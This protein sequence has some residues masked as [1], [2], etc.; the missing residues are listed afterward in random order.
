MED[1][2]QI[3]KTDMTDVVDADVEVTVETGAANV[4]NEAV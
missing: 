3:E 2:E 1:T 4:S